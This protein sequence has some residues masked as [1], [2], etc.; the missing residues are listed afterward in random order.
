MS[1]LLTTA[2]HFTIG[3]ARLSKYKYYKP[4]ILA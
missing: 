3:K 1:I 2:V 4:S